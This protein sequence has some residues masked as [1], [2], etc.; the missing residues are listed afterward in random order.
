MR[1]V[2]KQ[3]FPIG[4]FHATPWRVNPFDDPHGEWPPSPWRLARAVVARWYQWAR[5]AS[6]PRPSSELDRLVSAMCASRFGFFL[7]HFA[8]RGSALRQYLPADFSWNPG[9]KKSAAMRSYKRSLAQDNYWC[10]APGDEGAVWWFIEGDKWNDELAEVLDR[11]LERITYFGRAETFTRITRV[12]ANFPE[13]NCALV[14][15]PKAGAVPVLVP[16][17]EAS[18]VDLERVTEDEEVA[19]RSVPLGATYRYAMRPGRPLVNEAAGSRRPRAPRNFIQF[20]IGWNVAPELRATIRLT[21]RFRGAVIRQ[22]V[23]A[24]SNGKYQSWSKAPHDL[25]EKVALMTGKDAGGRP[26]QG[27]QHAE[28]F[29]W[30]EDGAPTRLLV[31]RK[32]V[33]FDEDEEGAILGAASKALSWAAQGNADGVWKVRLVPLDRAVPPP[34]GFDRRLYRIWESVTP[35]VPARRYLRG[36]RLRERETVDNQVRRELVARGWIGEGEPVQVAFERS[37]W[38][39]VH[40]PRGARHKRSFLGDRQGYRLRVEF[41]RPVEGPLRLGHSSTFGLGLLRPVDQ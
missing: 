8:R 1:I 35:Y 28:F 25:R 32:S 14:E 11:C 18:R 5:E 29:I 15:T 41:P 12:S 17:A 34:P 30:Y 31:W 36:G 21:S 19:R 7:P 20:A 2:L 27:H 33:P 39:A 9:E 13:P 40:L 3:V 38:V 22:L 23:A 37:S 6:H 16:L 4:R 24:K 26:L 10:T